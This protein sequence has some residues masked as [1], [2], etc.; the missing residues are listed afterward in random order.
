MRRPF[1]PLTLACHALQTRFNAATLI[2]IKLYCRT[3]LRPCISIITKDQKTVIPNQSP[4]STSTRNLQKYISTSKTDS[5]TGKLMVQR[6]A[7]IEGISEAPAALGV[8]TQWAKYGQPYKDSLL[9]GM[10]LRT[11]QGFDPPSVFLFFYFVCFG[12]WVLGFGFWVL[13]FGFWVLGFFCQHPPPPTLLSMSFSFPTNRLLL[14]PLFA[15][16]IE[17]CA[18]FAHPLEMSCFLLVPR[19]W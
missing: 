17:F 2:T 16:G 1:S 3:A 15:F 18:H 14:A 6:S 4:F 10:G 8:R 12:F 7:I 9:L 19:F 13:G 5:S 11:L